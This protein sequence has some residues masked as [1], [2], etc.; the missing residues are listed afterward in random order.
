[1]FVR[2]IAVVVVEVLSNIPS[3]NLAATAFLLS[4]HCILLIFSVV[5][6]PPPCL[7]SQAMETH[8]L[9]PRLDY[10]SLFDAD[11]FSIFSW[12]I[13]EK[14]EMKKDT[15]CHDFCLVFHTLFLKTHE[16]CQKITQ[17]ESRNLE[18]TITVQNYTCNAHEHNISVVFM[19]Y[20][21]DYVFSLYKPQG[22]GNKQ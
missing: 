2:G 11:E 12:K 20:E 21:L 14:T 8:R 19:F 16:F 10:Q 6:T 15:P 7:L 17:G 3:L 1:M 13:Q 22:Q 4:S 9:S 5:I 18:K